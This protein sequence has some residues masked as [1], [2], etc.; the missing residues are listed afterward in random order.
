MKQILLR[1]EDAQH[2]AFKAA[3]AHHPGGMQGVLEVLVDSYTKHETERSI[4][5]LD[6]SM[7]PVSAMI[8]AIAACTELEIKGLMA[9]QRAPTTPPAGGT[10]DEQ[11]DDLRSM[12]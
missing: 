6:G 12:R 4:H 10:R 3:A 1:L 7:C 2:S 11:R 9:R 5:H 8:Q